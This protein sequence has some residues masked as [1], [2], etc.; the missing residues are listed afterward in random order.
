MFSTL[1]SVVYNLIVTSIATHPSGRDALGAH[2]Y[3]CIVLFII[4][5]LT[6]QN[7]AVLCSLDGPLPNFS[8]VSMIR[9]LVCDNLGSIYFPVVPAD[10]P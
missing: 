9:E 3:K 6:L 5:S 10:V 7:M 8:P 2:T 4:D 1:D